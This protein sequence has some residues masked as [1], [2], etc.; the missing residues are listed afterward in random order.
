MDKSTALTEIWDCGNCKY[1]EA[2]DRQ[3]L[4]SNRKRWDKE[5]SSR[6]NIHGLT[7]AIDEGTCKYLE[8]KNV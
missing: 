3:W 1:F 8:K 4:C 2:D 6:S 5:P 7:I